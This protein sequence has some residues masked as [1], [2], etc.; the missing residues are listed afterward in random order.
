MDCA[1]GV[2]SKKS[3]PYPKS[4]R[5]L[6][7]LSPRSFIFIYFYFLFFVHTTQHAGSQFSGQGSNQCPLQWKCRVL[8][9]GPRGKSLDPFFGCRC[10]VVPALVEKA[11][12]APLYCLCSFVKDQLAI[13]MW[14]YFWAFYSFPLIFLSILAPIPQCLDY[15]SFIVSLDVG[16]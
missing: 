4:S 2:V 9:A 3:L 15:C 6:P 12:F 7:M 10:P 16:Q 14:I 1:F 5:F 11:V 8:T 13:F